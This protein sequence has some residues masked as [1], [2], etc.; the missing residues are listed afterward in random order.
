MGE[1]LLKHRD[2]RLSNESK[3]NS[4]LLKE[5]ADIAIGCLNI[6][7][8]KRP[9]MTGIVR[10]LQ[11]LFNSCWTVREQELENEIQQLRIHARASASS[12]SSV[13]KTKKRYCVRCCCDFPWT[14][15]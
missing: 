12:E 15:E 8:G 1:W 3:A 4:V 2:S 6:E 11:L 7:P 13:G 14:T 5:L 9:N 10:R